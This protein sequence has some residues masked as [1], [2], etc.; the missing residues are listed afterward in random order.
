MHVIGVKTSQPLTPVGGTA[1]EN[2]ANAMLKLAIKAVK[3]EINLW[4]CAAVLQ[5]RIGWLYCW[6]KAGRF[7]PA[8]LPL[9]KSTRQSER[10]QRL[11]ADL[12][13]PWRPH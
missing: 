2:K 3:V 11:T 4:A 10:L 1:D 8:S 12:F 5:A 9:R 7:A 13:R 6:R